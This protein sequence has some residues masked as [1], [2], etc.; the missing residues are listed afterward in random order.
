MHFK[1]NSHTAGTEGRANGPLERADCFLE[2][3]ARFGVLGDARSLYVSSRSRTCGIAGRLTARVTEPDIQ[4]G[5]SV[6]GRLPKSLPNN[7]GIVPRRSRA[8]VGRG[9]L[10]A[11]DAFVPGSGVGPTQAQKKAPA[12]GRASIISRPQPS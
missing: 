10:L 7:A 12:Q 2:T 4:M 6:A 5:P 9:C 1:S 3:C 8:H 11:H